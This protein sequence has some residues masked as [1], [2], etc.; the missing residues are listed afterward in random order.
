MEEKS[1]PGTT[2]EIIKKDDSKVSEIG[3]PNIDEIMVEWSKLPKGK[4]PKENVKRKPVKKPK[5]E[6]P[7]DSE[8]IKYDS[9]N[10]IEPENNWWDNHFADTDDTQEQPI[11]EEKPETSNILRSTLTKENKKTEEKQ[12]VITIEDVIKI[13]HDY[14]TSYSQV[15][16]EN[17]N[18]TEVK[19]EVKPNQKNGKQLV[20][21]ILFKK[22]PLTNKLEKVKVLGTKSLKNFD[23]KKYKIVTL[24]SNKSTTGKIL[25]RLYGKVRLFD[26]N[27]CDKK[28]YTVQGRQRHN[29]EEHAT[30]AKTRVPVKR[31]KPDSNKRPT[32]EVCSKEFSSFPALSTHRKIHLEKKFLCNDCGKLFISSPALK[33]HQITHSG[34]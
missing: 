4:R 11:P 20:Q 3:T 15:N 30:K 23:P 2:N 26:C 32:C 9:D 16:K 28:F 14:V 21:K 17:V 1:K 29:K 10:S 8:E 33:K 24:E 12:K 6:F 18:T 25:Q 7:S 19:E 34:N 5:I 22:N 31:Q 13:E 27:K